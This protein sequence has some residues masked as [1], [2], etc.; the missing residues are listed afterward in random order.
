MGIAFPRKG[1]RRRLRTCVIFCEG[2]KTEP[3]YFDTLRRKLNV[4]IAIEKD[5][6][7]I[8]A[9]S[10]KLEHPPHKSKTYDIKACLI[11]MDVMSPEKIVEMNALAL[12]Y[13][14]DIYWSN[15]CFEFWL[16][17]HFD[18]DDLQPNVLPGAGTCGPFA[19]RHLLSFL[20]Y[21]SK[22]L[23][24]SVCTKL[25]NNLDKALVN[26][27]KLSRPFTKPDG[28][29]NTMVGDLVKALM[30]QSRTLAT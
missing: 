30:R 22:D 24:E 18:R 5:I 3:A 19:E 29:A 2:K 17:L 21:F 25:M 23:D 6:K 28:I 4:S 16:C 8:P 20:P 15:P 13:K 14:I 10:R 1:G 9:M 27:T 26:Y 12:E 7:D 11:D